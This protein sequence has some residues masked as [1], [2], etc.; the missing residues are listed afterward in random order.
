MRKGGGGV[1]ARVCACVWLYNVNP[2]CWSSWYL[3]YISV[4]WLYFVLE[5]R[6]HNF[7]WD[8]HAFQRLCQFACSHYSYLWM[9]RYTNLFYS[10]YKI[11]CWRRSWWCHN[12]SQGVFG[13]CISDVSGHGVSSLGVQEWCWCYHIIFIFHVFLLLL[14]IYCHSKIIASPAGVHACTLA[15]L[16]ASNL[17]ITVLN[18]PPI[19]SPR[20]QEM[21]W[22]SDGDF[23]WGRDLLMLSLSKRERVSKCLR[24]RG[25]EKD[26]V[27]LSER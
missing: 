1:R 18:I 15:A 19:E 10:T 12:R 25:E 2:L 6:L 20:L 24:L 4:G 16:K 13:K 5:W 17:L 3:L 8:V 23:K 7:T 11:R 14:L 9:K 22:V 21:R 27:T 26:R